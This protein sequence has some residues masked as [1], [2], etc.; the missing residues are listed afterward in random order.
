MATLENRRSLGSLLGGELVAKKNLPAHF[1]LWN[2]QA[3]NFYCVKYQDLGSYLLLHYALFSRVCSKNRFEHPKIEC[4]CSLKQGM[5]LG[6]RGISGGA[7][8]RGLLDDNLCSTEVKYLDKLSDAITWEAD[9]VPAEWKALGRRGRK[10][11]IS[12]FRL[13]LTVFNKLLQEKEEFRQEL[14]SSQMTILGKKSLGCS[15]LGKSSCFWTRR[16]GQ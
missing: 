12:V 15:K 16:G 4:G 11:R 3:I 9:H 8:M 14:S 13:L 1:K 10:Y 5:G 6:L 7:D 2:E